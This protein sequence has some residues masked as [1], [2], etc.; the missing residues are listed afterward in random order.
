MVNGC[1]WDTNE[2][3]NKTRFLG[4]S[5]LSIKTNELTW[6]G[7]LKLPAMMV[8]PST[9]E[10]FHHTTTNIYIYVDIL[11]NYIIIYSIY[12]YV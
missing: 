3:R 8:E 11:Y 10:E 6:T 1:K 12:I 2:I 9:I 7:G 4:S 5:G